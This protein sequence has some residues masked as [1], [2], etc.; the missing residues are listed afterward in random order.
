M[1]MNNF[2]IEAVRNHWMQQAK[3]YGLSPEASWSDYRVIEMEIREITSHLSEEDRVLDIGCAN[4]YSTVQYAAQKKI[5]IRGLDYIPN[6]VELAKQRLQNLSI[7][8]SGKVEFCVGDITNLDEPNLYYDKVICTRVLIN[9]GEWVN[10]C[11]GL[12][13]SI[14]VLKPGANLLLSEATLQGWNQINKLRREW[15]LPDIPMPSF[16]R[17]IDENLLISEAT[18]KCDL[19]DVI[20]FS[21][22][23]YVG[24]RVIK[25]L[26]AK[27]LSVE[28]DVADPNM[29]LNK[30][31]A[32]L[33]AWGDCGIQKLFIFK[34]RK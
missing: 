32:N 15:Q 1:T 24:T 33:P 29:E 4:G 10:Q 16:N 20:N 5:E 9:L 22:T 30:W 6:M 12:N 31:F 23:Y 13:E 3:K 21:S 34:K 8:L 11:K 17:Y 19:I 28:V 2:D 26:L 27:A 18:K 25:P 14:R 7:P